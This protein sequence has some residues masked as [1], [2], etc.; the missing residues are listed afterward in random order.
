MLSLSVHY[1]TERER[2]NPCVHLVGVATS[3]IRREARGCLPAAGPQ[4]CM[5]YLGR[6]LRACSGNA[7][8]RGA[9]RFSHSMS[10]V[11]AEVD[12]LWW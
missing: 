3:L 5:R 1:R 10:P 11:G 8:A 2:K 4:R 6:I 9:H 7:V 12:T